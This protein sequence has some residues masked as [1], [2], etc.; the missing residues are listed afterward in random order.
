MVQLSK[1]WSAQHPGF[2][3]AQ[4]CE[5]VFWGHMVPQSMHVPADFPPHPRRNWS[6]RQS[7]TDVFAQLSITAFRG[8]H[9][10]SSSE[11]APSTPLVCRCSSAAP[12]SL[13]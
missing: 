13:G 8:W 1:P 10:A 11:R 4:P 3:R 9:C 6:S 12:P 7:R 5:V 2:L